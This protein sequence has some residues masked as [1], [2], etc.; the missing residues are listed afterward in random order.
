MLHYKLT[1]L[2]GPRSPGSK[3]QAK[4]DPS[5]SGRRTDW[6]LVKGLQVNGVHPVHGITKTKWEIS[7]NGVDLTN[8][9]GDVRNRV[10]KTVNPKP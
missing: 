7:N 8:Q 6:G 2:A 4:V 1:P 3:L 5:W 10:V 9:H